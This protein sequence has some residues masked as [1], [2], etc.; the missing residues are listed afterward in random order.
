MTLAEK[1][2]KEYQELQERKENER[3]ELENQLKEELS[4]ESIE[5][6]SLKE[7]IEDWSYNVQLAFTLD[8]YRQED[9]FYWSADKSQEDFI[10]HVKTRIDYIKELREE[11]SEF[12]KQNDYIQLNSK[13]CKKIL[14]T[15]MGYDR[16]FCFEV[17]LADFL[18]LP[19]QT[20]CS[21]GGGDYEI[22]RTPKRVSE[23]N[24]NIDVT[25]DI[26]LDCISE[27][28]NKKYV[29]NS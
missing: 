10:Q 14:L 12:C 15:H 17:K 29:S 24:K 22:K 11:Y 16:E 8:G 25:I 9:T 2:N 5:F 19:N 23:Y 4:L 26:L 27:L 18:K 20:S 1:K 7:N 28:K 3:L 6:L 21:V 13:F